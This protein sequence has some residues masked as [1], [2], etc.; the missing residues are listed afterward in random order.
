MIILFRILL[1]FSILNLVLSQ[2]LD[3][4]QYEYL[5]MK[6]T[7]LTNQFSVSI[8]PA[9]Q[10]CTIQFSKQF[11]AYCEN[12]VTDS[13]LMIFDDFVEFVNTRTTFEIEKSNGIF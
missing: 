1:L 3:V 12:R 5:T 9:L 11:F 13:Y 8:E 4:A 10:N 7:K 6:T 2:E